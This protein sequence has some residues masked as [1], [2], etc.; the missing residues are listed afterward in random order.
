[1]FIEQKLLKSIEWHGVLNTFKKGKEGEMRQCRHSMKCNEDDAD[2]NDADD[3]D[4]DDNDKDD[5]DDDD[6]INGRP[7]SNLMFQRM[8]GLMIIQNR[9]NPKTL[10]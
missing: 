2:V 4:D 7:F 8:H 3:D 5:N 10:K 1:M 9:V 6:Y